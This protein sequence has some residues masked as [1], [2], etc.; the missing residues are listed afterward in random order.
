MRNN[1]LRLLA[2]VLFGGFIVSALVYDHNNPPEK[3]KVTDL[4]FKYFSAKENWVDSTSVPVD[5][6]RLQVCGMMTRTKPAPILFRISDPN[7]I[8]KFLYLDEV[9]FE[10]GS[11]HFCVELLLAGEVSAGNYIL[12][13]MDGRRSVGQLMVEFVE[14]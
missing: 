6:R 14:K 4:Q 2:I 8:N 7:D 3:A 13:I 5:T 10:L 12:W 11:G 1:F 9:F